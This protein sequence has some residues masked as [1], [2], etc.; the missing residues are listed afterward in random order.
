MLNRNS[1]RAGLIKVHVH[2]TGIPNARG[3]SACLSV[4]GEIASQRIVQVP[5]PG[6]QR[7]VSGRVGRLAAGFESFAKRGHRCG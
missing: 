1:S 6:A 3:I 2:K 4:S 5:R 7:Y